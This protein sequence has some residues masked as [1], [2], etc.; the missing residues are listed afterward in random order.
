MT[1]GT[2]GLFDPAIGGI[3]LALRR[4][5]GDR[6]AQLGPISMSITT[7]PSRPGTLFGIAAGWGLLLFMG[8]GFICGRF[9]PPPGPYDAAT[10]ATYFHHDVDVKR[11]GVICLIVGGTMFIPFGAAIYERLRRV[12]GIGTVGATAQL[13]ASIATTTLMM[14]FG[15]FLLVALQRTDMPDS[16]YQLLNH[17]TWMAWAGLWQPG[18]LQAVSTAC[19]IFSDKSPTPVFP[20]WIGWYSLFMAFGSLTGSLIPFFVDGP[21]AWNGFIS[22]W[23]A[24]AVYFTWFAVMLTQ[25]HLASRRER[26]NTELTATALCGAP[27]QQATVLE[28]QFA[29]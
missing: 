28:R 13:G 15:P 25:L 22:F 8:A 21:F 9:L 23:V 26:N 17:V 6:T 2:V 18:A 12:E 11:L 1:Y 20:R 10:T 14:V 4:H 24:A 19:V 7:A 27:P 3:G 29:Q 5:G 16:T